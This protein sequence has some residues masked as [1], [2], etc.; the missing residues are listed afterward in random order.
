MILDVDVVTIGVERAEGP[1]PRL[2]HPGV[3]LLKTGT[4]EALLGAREALLRGD[5]HGDAALFGGGA[6]LV[7][8]EALLR[9]HVA[10]HAPVGLLCIGAR[11]PDKFHPGQGTELIA[12]LARTLEKTIAAWLDLAA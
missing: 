9:L 1:R 12:F 6:G 7:R 3:Q 11:R 10:E 5:I 2:P 4:V 8:S